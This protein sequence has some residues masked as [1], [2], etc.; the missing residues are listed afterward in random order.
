[1]KWR[2]IITLYR[3]RVIKACSFEIHRSNWIRL[4]SS[5]MFMLIEFVCCSSNAFSCH[6]N[7]ASTIFFNS[8]SPRCAYS[9]ND[10]PMLFRIHLNH[11]QTILKL[12]YVI[13]HC[14]AV[15]DWNIH[16][17]YG[18]DDRCWQTQLILEVKHLIL[19]QCVSNKS[20]VY[21]L[22]RQKSRLPYQYI[23]QV[24]CKISSHKTWYT[25]VTNAL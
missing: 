1:M 12:S 4:Y 3:C 5:H 15:L 16:S 13:N 20:K 18:R 9:K 7:W 11:R 10:M 6:K 8:C 22:L 17:V 23:F 24:I 25:V 21:A 2:K 14:V 19:L